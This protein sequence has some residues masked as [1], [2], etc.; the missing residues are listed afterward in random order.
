[1]QQADSGGSPLLSTEKRSQGPV[2]V[3]LLHK[4]RP[5]VC[6]SSP[7]ARRHFRM[8]TPPWSCAQSVDRVAPHTSAESCSRAPRGERARSSAAAASSRSSSRV[9]VAVASFRSSLRCART[10]GFWT[11]RSRAVAR[12]SAA[13]PLCSPPRA[14][15]GRCSF[16]GPWQGEKNTGGGR[17]GGRCGETPAARRLQ[18][19]SLSHDH[20]TAL[21]P[22]LQPSSV[23]GRTGSMR[24]RRCR[25]RRLRPS[26]TTA[27]PRLC[28]RL[29]ISAAPHS[30][31]S[32]TQRG[33]S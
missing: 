13:T 26:L 27:T 14:T 19:Y 31:A 10:G 32:C 9:V 25:Q 6:V 12:R 24:L 3:F 8:G 11:L 20:M 21:T 1:M 23:T 17:Q 28:P 7:G 4:K 15:T 33:S 22:L 2:P 5:L 16:S 18:T 30:P 29:R